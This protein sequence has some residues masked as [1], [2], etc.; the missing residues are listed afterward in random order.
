MNR[1]LYN[2]LL[3]SFDTQLPEKERKNVDAALAGSERLRSAKEDIA[4]LRGALR[5]TRELKFS[6]FFAERVVQQ[7]RAPQQPVDEYF[8]SVFGRLAAGAALLV[9][10]LSAYNLTQSNAISLESALGIH[11]SSLQQVLTLEVPFE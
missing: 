6:P 9:L 11:Q 1:S 10:L 3:R 8:V 2:L 5:S 4:A 7:L